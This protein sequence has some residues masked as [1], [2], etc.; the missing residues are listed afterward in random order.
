M[1]I[2]S[3]REICRECE[4]ALVCKREP[5]KKC[6]CAIDDADLAIITADFA[7]SCPQKKWLSEISL[8][9]KAILIQKRKPICRECT[10]LKCIAKQEYGFIEVITDPRWRCPEGKYD[11]A[12]W[13]IH[14]DAS[15]VVYRDDGEFLYPDT[16]NEQKDKLFRQRKTICDSCGISKCAAHNC[17][18]G[19]HIRRLLESCAASC[20][21]G[22]WPEITVRRSE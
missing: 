2:E 11:S 12:T 15:S 22:A 19:G 9:E 10:S 16:P 5:N 21:T 3:R 18:C 14:K 6:R 13:S 20:P 1:S 4:H 7:A 17:G 8:D